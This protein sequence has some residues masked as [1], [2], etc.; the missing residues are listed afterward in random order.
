MNGE[1]AEV[2]EEEVPLRDGVA[3]TVDVSSEKSKL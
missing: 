3:G 2:E 1:V